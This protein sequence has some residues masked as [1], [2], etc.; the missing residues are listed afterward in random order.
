MDDNIILIIKKWIHISHEV[1]SDCTVNIGY[2]KGP[3]II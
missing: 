1:C 3:F 2:V